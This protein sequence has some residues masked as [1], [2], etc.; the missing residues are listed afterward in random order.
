MVLNLAVLACLESHRAPAVC[1]LTRCGKLRC[2][3]RECQLP[4]G[5]LLLYLH[6]RP[7]S[8][9]LAASLGRHC[10]AKCLFKCFADSLIIELN[11]SPFPHFLLVLFFSKPP[12]SAL[13]GNLSSTLG[14]AQQM[15]VTVLVDAGLCSGELLP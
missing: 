1:R 15:Q 7:A 11:A 6:S 2:R 14:S 12:G 8:Q 13:N 5:F 4:G 9:H 10:E 3:H